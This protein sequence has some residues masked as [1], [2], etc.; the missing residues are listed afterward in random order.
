[1]YDKKVM[2]RYLLK[3]KRYNY[4]NSSYIDVERFKKIDKEL[5]GE[6]TTKISV[7]SF[8]LFFLMMLSIYSKSS[9]LFILLLLPTYI[10][11][12]LLISNIYIRILYYICKRELKK[13]IKSGVVKL[14]SY[15]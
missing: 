14:G 1:M 6:Y 15:K 7:V 9:L 10:C 13:E 2:R 4:S 11:G 12:E 8:M 3:R 5:N